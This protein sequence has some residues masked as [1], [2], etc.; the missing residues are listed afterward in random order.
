M[1][2]R[3][4]VFILV[5]DSSVSLWNILDWSKF[6]WW[7]KNRCSTS[8][9]SLFALGISPKWNDWESV[10]FLWTFSQ[11]YFKE[12]HSSNRR[13]RGLSTWQWCCASVESFPLFIEHLIIIDLFD[14]Q[15]YQ[16]EKYHVGRRW[17]HQI[18]RFRLCQTSEEESKHTF[19]AS[20]AQIN[21]RLSRLW[22]VRSLVDHRLL[23]V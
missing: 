3:S 22:S 13:R 10:S 23:F 7:E 4:I 14:F 16:R 12:I 6:T 2:H 8:N 9:D 19:D 11:W 1:I 17:K 21:E 18:D 5:V 15:R 20:F